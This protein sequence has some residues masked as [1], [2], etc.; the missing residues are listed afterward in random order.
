MF[1]ESPSLLVPASELASRARALGA[2]LRAAALDGAFL[3][4]P[5]SAFWLTGTI[6]DGFAFLDADGRVG[7]PV[8]R[9]LARSALDTSTPLAPIRRPEDLP[10]A[11]AALGLAAKGCVGLEMDVVPV[12]VAERLKRVFPH[13]TFQDVSPCVRAARAVKSAYEIAWIEQA[14]EISRVV[15]DERVPFALGE[16]VPE[17]EVMAF[18]ES[19]LRLRRHQGTIRLRRWTMEMHYGTVSSGPS[20]LH[21][22]TFDGPDGLEAL[23]PAVQQGGG[24]RRLVRGLPILVDFVGA[25]GGYLADRSRVFSIGEPPK[26]ARDAHAFCREVL[27]TIESRLRPGAIP[28]AIHAE[29]LA[30]AAASPWANGF[31]GW[32]EN[33]VGFIGHGVGLD[34]DE[35][36]VLAPRFDEPLAPGN[37]L[38]IEPKT[39]LRDIGGVGVENTYVVTAD[40]ARNLTPGPE[41]LR[42]V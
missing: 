3:L 29:A 38:A 21:P 6:A 30:L 20:A 23:Y 9:S 35:L 32:G 13:V 31:L 41:D 2:R 24:E 16:G 36:P 33:R 10:S 25:A 39:F 22:C 42:V 40:G 17:I 5:S 7:L 4:H 15:M 18:I 14:A 28:S 1:V 8:R 11:L 12:A 37:V 19:E 26:E 34:L 27:R